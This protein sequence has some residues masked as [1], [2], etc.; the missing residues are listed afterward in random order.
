MLKKTMALLC[1]MIAMVAA[2]YADDVT[3]PSP[4]PSPSPSPVPTPA[5][6]SAP[7]ALSFNLGIG[8]GYDVFNETDG[9]Q[10]L[11]LKPDFGVGEFGI[12]LSIILHFRFVSGTLE[13]RTEDWVPDATHSVWDLYLPIFRY[14]RYGQKGK[15]LFLKLG[16]MDDMTLGNGY[17]MGNYTNTL[18]L[19]QTR[20]VGLVADLDGALFDFPLVGIETVIG[21]LA[22]LDVMG[23]RLYV[24]P[25]IF[26]DI[27]IL[28]NLQLGTTFIA[29]RLPFRYVSAAYAAGSGVPDPVYGV[30]QAFGLDFRQPLLTESPVTLAVYGDLVWLDGGKASGQMAGFGGKLLDIF[31]YN[32]QMR[33]NGANFIP[34]YFDATYDVSRAVKYPLVEA[35][36]SPGFAGWYASLGAEI[37]D[38]FTIQIGLDGPFGSVDPADPGN[39][40]NWPHLR[41]VVR[42]GKGLIPGLSADLIYDKT[43]L[44]KTNGFFA[45]LFDPEGAVTTVRVNYQFG[46][47]VISLLFDIRYVPDASGNPWVITSSLESS[48]V[49]PF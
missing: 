8:L 37:V 35:G 36:N 46:P 5:P 15:P 32:F 25:F 3:P 38:V 41:G 27:P 28:Q 12:G 17:I 43:L 22:A 47:A 48:V 39:Y 6:E 11:E 20:I 4:S 1:L 24:R 29:D 30:A 40:L 18:F 16:S 21:N 7:P 9:F 10:R 23:G 49:I 34:V 14:A 26:F 42:L 19:P 45:D 2:V 44:G 13:F 31:T 33:F